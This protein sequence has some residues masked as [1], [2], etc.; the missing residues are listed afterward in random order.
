MRAAFRLWVT[1]LRP[2]WIA[3]WHGCAATHF[4]N[5]DA[6][7]EECVMLAELGVPVLTV[8][9]GKWIVANAP[10]VNIGEEQR[11][12]VVHLRML[13]E[14]LFC[15][16]TR[17]S[18]GLVLG[19]P[20]VV[21]IPGT[22][23]K[24]GLNGKDGKDGVNGKDGKDGVNGKDG[25][26]GKDGQDAAGDFVEHPAGLPRYAIVAAG[27]VKGDS[28]NRAP[29]YADLKASVGANGEYILNFKGYKPPDGKFQLIVK[30]LLVQ[31]KEG[32]L[33]SPVVMFRSFQPQG[34]LLSI[35]DAGVQVNPEIARQVE[36]MVEIS[37]FETA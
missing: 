10:P 7:E 35:I 4:A 24:D 29:V 25:K 36:L 28:T 27:I 6:T 8:S 3:R 22:P 37:R 5:D 16:P 31:P 23:G 11:P 21:G 30:I 26:D 2:K 33:R 9:P 20:P 18:S 1:E 34:I 15:G 14:W 17:K 19:S 13:Q 12:Y 32:V